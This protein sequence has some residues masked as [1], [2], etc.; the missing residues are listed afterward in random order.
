MNN[1]ENLR[2]YIEE[3]LES[4]KIT[5]DIRNDII[6]KSKINTYHNL[7]YVAIIALPILLI[8][9]L[10]FS[11]PISYAAQRVL[12]YVPGINK[13]IYTDV[14]KQA[15][16]LLGS[17][18][19]LIGEKYIKVNSAYT[20]GN[21]VTLIIEGNVPLKMEGKKVLEHQ[22]IAID[23]YKN[24]AELTSWDMIWDYDDYQWSGRIT[25]T[26]NDVVKKFN[27]VYDKY[28]MPIVMTELP[29]VSSKE[30][31]YISI[32]DIGIDIAVV[33]N[34]VENKLEVNLLAQAND[35]AKSISFP[36]KDIYL[37]DDN[38]EKY[39][40]INNN[41][42]NVLYFD[43]KLEPCIKLVI[44]YILIED[45]DLQ[46]KVTI[47]KDNE[48]PINI[49]L[50]DNNLIINS[51]EWVDYIERFNY[52]TP[53]NDCKLIE[54]AAQKVKLIINKNLVGTKELKLYNILANVD[55]NELN[56]YIVEGVKCIFVDPSEENNSKITNDDYKELILSNIKEGQ[57]EINV[58][59]TNPI[60]YTTNKVII[61]IQ[62]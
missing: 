24:V 19:M 9:C 35:S 58:T 61:P 36:L 57:Q 59:F 51:V 22:I 32:E 31:N 17:V 38:G 6:R 50:G 53:E 46:A 7:K 23:E 30:R 45:T 56:K 43:R 42:E 8:L 21:T 20:E 16:G 39:Y 37:L 27:I 28:T 1:L 55:E 4:I 44:P 5:D 47:S 14:K 33:T 34:Y 2:D 15:Y 62:P 54:K 60:F 13:L 25:Y 52:K 29:E 41:S 49:K 3:N 26:F 18:E 40:C 11:D 10:A 48:L 12:R